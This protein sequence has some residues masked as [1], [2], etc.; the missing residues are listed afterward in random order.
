M[1]ESLRV[2]NYLAKSLL[3]SPSLAFQRSLLKEKVHEEGSDDEEGRDGPDDECGSG[4][5]LV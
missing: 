3:L 1:Q 4:D 2:R 5:G